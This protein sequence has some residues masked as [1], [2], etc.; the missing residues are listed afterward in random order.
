MYQA[1]I[2]M[3]IDIQAETLDEARAKARKI[4][5][6]LSVLPSA[7]VAG[8]DLLPIRIYDQDGTLLYPT[9]PCVRCGDETTEERYETA[10]LCNY[11]TH[12]INKEV[13]R[14]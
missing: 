7:H 5:E 1:I 9:P 2:P 10:G 11:C 3:I 13:D 8:N 12:I 6:Q 14:D 4:A